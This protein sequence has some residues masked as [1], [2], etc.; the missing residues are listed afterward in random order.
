MMALSLIFLV[1]MLLICLKFLKIAGKN[2]TKNN[3]IMAAYFI[4]HFFLRTLEILLSNYE[5]NLMLTWYENCVVSCNAAT[6]HA[7]TFAIT[8]TKLYVPVVI[9]SNPVMQSCFNT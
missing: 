2:D 8:D 7:T 6:N 9:L 1:T 4:S 5:I 3:A